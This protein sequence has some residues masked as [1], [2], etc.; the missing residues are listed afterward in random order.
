MLP[1]VFEKYYF[2]QSLGWGI[3][4]SLWQAALLWM[5]YQ[6]ITAANNSLSALFKHHLSLVLLCSSFAW[7]VITT[8]Q[9]YLLAKVSGNGVVAAD[10]IYISKNVA[11]A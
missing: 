1:A 10:Q 8:V 3:A 6:L 4:N 7:F 11:A 9:N 2:L 5:I